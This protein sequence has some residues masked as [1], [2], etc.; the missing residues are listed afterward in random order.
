MGLDALPAGP[1]LAAAADENNFEL[2]ALRAQ[3]EQQGLRVDLAREARV[4]VVSVG[5]YYDRARSDIRE[6]NY[7]VRLSTTIPLWNRQAGE[8]AAEQGRQAQA[9][10]T[11][12]SAERR[13]TRDVFDR[14]AQYEAKR[15]ALARWGDEA[16]RRFAAAAAGADRNYRLGA[17]PLATYTQM[18]QAYVDATTAVLDTRREAIEALL[19]LRAL[20]GGDALPR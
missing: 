14:S 15:A 2:R 7:G 16:P 18:Q 20:N 9:N 3:L 8:V 5:P 17:I 13:V 4:P 6:T 19:Q 1:T 11:L 10:A 12:I